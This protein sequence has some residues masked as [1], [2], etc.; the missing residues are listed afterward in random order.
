MILDPFTGTG[1][2]PS[3]RFTS[4]IL[5]RRSPKDRLI[6]PTGDFVPARL[7]GAPPSTRGR[8]LHATNEITLRPDGSKELVAYYIAAMNIENAYG[9]GCRRRGR[10]RV[11]STGRSTASCLT[12]LPTPSR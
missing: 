6:A 9:R 3:S 7:L 5:M 11:R 10:S 1:S 12:S 2:R 8:S 4:S